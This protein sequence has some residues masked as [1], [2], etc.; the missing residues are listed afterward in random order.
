M[1]KYVILDVH[2]KDSRYHRKDDLIGSVVS[3]TN[4]KPMIT[5]TGVSGPWVGGTTDISNGW[6]HGYVKGTA[7]HRGI[8]ICTLEEYIERLFI[9]FLC[10]H[11]AYTPFMYNLGY[12]PVCTNTWDS[13]KVEQS[14]QKWFIAGFSWGESKEGPGFWKALHDLWNV[15]LLDI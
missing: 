3:A 6:C 14:A 13:Y 12:V 15:I 2:Q 1:Q 7:Y 10:E 9:K 11:K 4:I 5:R 8:K